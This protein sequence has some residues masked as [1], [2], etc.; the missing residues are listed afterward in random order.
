M[1]A[2]VLQSLGIMGMLVIMFWLGKWHERYEW[3]ELI[4]RGVVPKPSKKH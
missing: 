4:R 2:G 1:L 3:N